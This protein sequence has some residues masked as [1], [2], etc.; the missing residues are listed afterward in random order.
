LFIGCIMFCNFMFVF[1]VDLHAKLFFNIRFIFLPMFK[2]EWKI[3]RKGPAANKYD[4]LIATNCQMS[5]QPTISKQNYGILFCIDVTGEDFRAISA[6]NTANLNG[7]CYQQCTNC[8]SYIALN[9][10]IYTVIWKIRRES[11]TWHVFGR[12]NPNAENPCLE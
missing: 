6:D 10:V 1:H 7:S 2:L 4:V 5:S 11:S 3:V 8:W 12:T 9:D